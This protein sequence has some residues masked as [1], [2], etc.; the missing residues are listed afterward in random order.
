MNNLT[1]EQKEDLKNKLVEYLDKS[2]M[3]PYLVASLLAKIYKEIIKQEEKIINE[4]IER[5]CQNG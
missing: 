5:Y 2:G 3:M 4:R 1:E